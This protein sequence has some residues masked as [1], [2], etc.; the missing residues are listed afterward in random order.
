M[1]LAWR[2]HEWNALALLPRAQHAHAER[3]GDPVRPL[4][5]VVAADHREHEV[6]GRLTARAGRAI[7]I[8]FEDLLG[9]DRAFELFGE[10][11]IGFPVHAHA[12]AGQLPGHREPPHAVMNARDERCA[13]ADAREAREKQ[14]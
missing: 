2:G 8:D 13:L 5:A 1:A 12:I 4:R 11:L 7:A 10:L 14:P 6:D 9:D 3:I